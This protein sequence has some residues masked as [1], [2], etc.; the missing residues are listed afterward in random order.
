MTM[1]AS[2]PPVGRPIIRATSFWS[3]VRL[4]RFNRYSSDPLAATTTLI[5]EMVVE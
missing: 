1:M 4:G 5:I 3:P 2:R